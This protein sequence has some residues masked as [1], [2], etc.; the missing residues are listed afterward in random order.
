M[1]INKLTIN[2]FKNYGEEEFDFSPKVNVLTGNNGAGKTNVLDALYYLSFTKSYF[3]TI[4]NQNINYNSDYFLIKGVYK[5]NLDSIDT[6]SCAVKAGE[7][8][9]FKLNDKEYGRMADHIGLIPL[10]I[11]T[12]VDSSLVYGG[13]EER[14]RY[15]DGVISQFDKA[16]LDVLLNYNKVLQQR[17]AFLKYMAENRIGDNSQL[18]IWDE[19]MA[20]L[21]EEIHRKRKEFLDEFIPVIRDFYAFI[22]QDKELTGIEYRSHLNNLSMSEILK[23][24]LSKDLGLR[25][26]T[27]GIHRDD[28]LFTVNNHPLRKFG[29][30]GQQKS[31]LVALKLAQFQYTKDKKGFK[32]LL[33]LDDIFDKLDIYRVEQMMKL[34]SRNEFGQIFI[35]DTNRSRI[36]KVFGSIEVKPRI[37]EIEDGRIKR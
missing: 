12:P 32:P 26:T 25:Y 33:L 22:A 1:Q 20:F 24:N 21:G 4:D 13:S 11:I 37:F 2:Y 36:E 28:I 23:Q 27:A 6:V 29:S 7:R 16:Y 15:I 19:K 10:V 35:T 30:Q 31:F 34:V 18:E 3:N 8:K 17:N 14:R 5:N 9:R